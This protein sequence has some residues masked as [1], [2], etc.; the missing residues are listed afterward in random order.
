MSDHTT[1][2]A[3]TIS[4]G[5]LSRLTGIRNKAILAAI[6]AEFVTYCQQS[7]HDSWHLAWNQF[8]AEVAGKFP[9]LV[10]HRVYLDSSVPRRPQGQL[11]DFLYAGNGCF[12]SAERD[13]IK[14]IIP[15]SHYTVRGVA[16]LSPRVELTY[17][18]VPLQITQ[19]IVEIF[20]NEGHHEVLL[21]LT[22]KA[23]RWELT[24]P[25]QKQSR[26]A[27]RPLDP[28]EREDAL[29]EIHSHH[30]MPPLFS[31]EDDAAE[32]AFRLYAVIGNFPLPIINTRLS[33]FGHFYKVKSESIFE[34]G[35]L[36]SCQNR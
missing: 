7:T 16:N 35:D 25:A 27:V 30:R 9:N 22:P 11:Y 31:P 33:V 19:Q 18:E 23:D 26:L 13:G 4:D 5:T 6:Q 36:Q 17:P 2:D 24:R 15:H 14:A 20:S 21:Y 34:L 1:L 12:I 28:E 3:M 8:W 29:I 32:T 10:Q